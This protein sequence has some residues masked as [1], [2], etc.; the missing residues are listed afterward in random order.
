MILY[1]LAGIGK[2]AIAR[3]LADHERIK[4]VFRD[5]IA[6]LDGSCDTEAEITRLCQALSL[7][8]RPDERWLECWR[9][10]AG[11]AERRLLLIIDDAVSAAGL[12][13]LIAGL[14]P[15]AVA[16]ITTQQGTEI[17]AEVE[18]WLPM[19]AILDVGIHGLAPSEGRALVEAV[20][21]RPLTDADWNMVQEIGERAGWHP[22]ALRLAAIESREIGWAGMLDELRASRMPW[23]TLRR[24]LLGQI[25]ELGPEQRGWLTRLNGGSEPG[26]WFDETEVAR[27]WSVKTAGA[28]RRLMLLRRQGL[29]QEAGDPP[30]WRM[31]PAL[32]LAMEP[33][34]Q[35]DAG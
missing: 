26:A 7:E 31:E 6:W 10:W 24:R 5:G 23:P 29:V 27:R 25:A 15:Q 30:R 11:A 20:I 28:R 17:R 18:R 8:L 9:R 33:D 22:E 12:P 32:R 19:D 1:G 21:A 16:L 3:S 14:G 34:G 4:D 2:T 35:G 13:P